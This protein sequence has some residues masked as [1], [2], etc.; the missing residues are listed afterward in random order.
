MITMCNLNTKKRCNFVE[1]KKRIFVLGNLLVKEDALAIELIPELKKK[2]PDIDFTEFDPLEE[3]ES[4]KAI[5]IDVVE[6]IKNVE[7]IRDLR[8][9]ETRKIYSTHDFDAAILLKILKKLGI[10]KEI[11]ILGIPKGMKKKEA[12]RE[13]EKEIRKIF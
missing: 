6:G 9:I 12:L 7:I 13:L 8:K 2:F 10:I 4:E 5:F 11:I 1:N 3:I